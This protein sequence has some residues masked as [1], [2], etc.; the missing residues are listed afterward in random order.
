MKHILA[1]ITL[2]SCI[3]TKVK[4]KAIETDESVNSTAADYFDLGRLLK[5]AWSPFR[6]KMPGVHL[7]TF[8]NI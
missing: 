7:G 5:N 6:Y 8:K 4:A 3:L 1:F 2:A